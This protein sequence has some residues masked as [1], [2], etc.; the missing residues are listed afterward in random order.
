M[1]YGLLNKYCRNVLQSLW[2]AWEP[3]LNNLYTLSRL[4]HLWGTTHSVQYHDLA[5]I[6]WG[7]LN[8]F[9]ETSDK[10]LSVLLNTQEALNYLQF[11]YHW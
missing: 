3:Y 6:G 4:D 9:E 8:M 11:A 10:Y 1:Q 7:Y 5:L 2:W